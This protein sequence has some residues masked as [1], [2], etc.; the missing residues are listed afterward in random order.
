MQ[1]K[2]KL[3]TTLTLAA[4][5]GATA[6][7]SS[8]TQSGP[9]QLAVE[10]GA[11]AA[12]TALVA[13]MAEAPAVSEI[14]VYVTGVRVHE[15]SSG[16]IDIPLPAEFPNPVDLKTLP[17]NPI[18]GLITL[19]AGSEITQIRLLVAKEGNY[20]V[21]DAGTAVLNVPSGYQSGIKIIGKWKIGACEQTTVTLDLRGEKAIW[22]HPTGTGE[23]RLRPTIHTKATSA[24]AETCEEP[25]PTCVPEECE[26]G[27][28]SETDEC[29][30]PPPLDG[31]CTVDAEC[32]TGV[33]LEGACG[34]G[35]T[36]A[37]CDDNA[38]CVSDAC[39]EDLLC[40]PPALEGFD[41]PCESGA[42]CLSG[43]C[44]EL[45]LCEPS[46]ESEPCIGSFDCQFDLLCGTA[47][48]CVLPANL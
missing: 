16:W 19:P 1:L 30:P 7:G 29:V 6:C 12:P 20:V 13:V 46:G 47:G 32:L 5:I 28:C 11:V 10:L 4:G 40:D 27:A 44:S 22:Y 36:D 26:T 17:T 9:G 21:T 25:G 41:A 33:C 3:I 8:S 14:G 35:G 23:W 18:L 37:P 42:D 45:N 31:A 2:R 39:G 38:D 24:P 34:P 15:V 43:D 48:V